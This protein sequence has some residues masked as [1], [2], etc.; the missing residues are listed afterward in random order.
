MGV[1]A[2][3]RQRKSRASRKSAPFLLGSAL[4]AVHVVVA[5]VAGGALAAPLIAIVNGSSLTANATPLIYASSAA[6]YGDGAQGFCDDPSLAALT[7]RELA[8]VPVP[9]SSRWV[10]KL[11]R[12]E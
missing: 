7:G 6:T 1:A 3:R 4:L 10:A 12:S 11:C 5:V 2:N 8:P 9:A